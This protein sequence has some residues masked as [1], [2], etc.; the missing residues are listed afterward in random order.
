MVII[1]ATDTHQTTHFNIVLKKKSFIIFTCPEDTTV[2]VQ[3]QRVYDILKFVEF[4]DTVDISLNRIGPYIIEFNL[5]QTKDETTSVWITTEQCEEET[6]EL[7]DLTKRSYLK[8]PSK[9]FACYITGFARL[10][11][12]IQ[13]KSTRNSFQI[14]TCGADSDISGQRTIMPSK[15]KIVFNMDDQPDSDNTYKG[16]L[17][18]KAAKFVNMNE[19]VLI[20]PHS[21]EALC[22]SYSL[23][24]L[25][26]GRVDIYIAPRKT[27]R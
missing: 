23:G 2:T 14:L 19:T 21:S 27:E 18:Q 10:A 13:L 12:D 4:N 11:Q 9:E 25:D 15:S 7:P 17:L 6:N 24:S 26:K 3:A 20:Y 8:M 5:E 1:D 22:I 16:E